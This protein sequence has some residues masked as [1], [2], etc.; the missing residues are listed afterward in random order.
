MDARAGDDRRSPTAPL[1]SFHVRNGW[2]HEAFR[3]Y[4]LR[5]AANVP[6]T[7]RQADIARIV[8]IIPSL[9]SKWFRGLEQP[10]DASLR[11]VKSRFAAHGVTVRL[12]DLARL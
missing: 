7:D 9:L 3:D 4:I 12:D 6:G 11:K 2:D 1:V 5:A 10:S 8:V